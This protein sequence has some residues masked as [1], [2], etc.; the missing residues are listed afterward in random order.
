M[1]EMYYLKKIA[2]VYKRYMKEHPNTIDDVNE[3]WDYIME[4]LPF[5][6][7]HLTKQIIR[8]FKDNLQAF[9]HLKWGDNI[10][11]AYWYDFNHNRLNDDLGGNMGFMVTAQEPE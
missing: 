6:K 8:M 5:K 4:H 10:D 3:V 7:K 11:S 1:E 9:S 2:K